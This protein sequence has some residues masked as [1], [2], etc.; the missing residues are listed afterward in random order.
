MN[1]NVRDPLTNWFE[2]LPIALL[3]GMANGLVPVV[4]P[5]RSGISELI[6]DQENGI[7]VGDRSDAVVSAIRSLLCEQAKTV[8]LS[9]AARQTVL[10]NYSSSM[11]ASRWESLLRRLSL[12]RSTDATIP[13]APV[14]L[15]LPA[16]H[17]ALAAEDR[18]Q[19]PIGTTDYGVFRKL[20]RRL[21]ELRRRVSQLV[22]R[23]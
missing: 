22:D 3:E 19:S 23:D 18:R 5:M 13:N 12:S 2:G 7:V 16:V 6:R 9:S 4:S 20:T 8:R 21:V 11:C 10:Q 14:D 15:M 17:P 1:P